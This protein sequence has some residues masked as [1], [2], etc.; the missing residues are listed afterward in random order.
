VL[1]INDGVFYEFYLAK[2][3]IKYPLLRIT[4]LYLRARDKGIANIDYVQ[5]LTRMLITY[6]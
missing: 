5:W 1:R 2:F 6:E 3:C 4:Y